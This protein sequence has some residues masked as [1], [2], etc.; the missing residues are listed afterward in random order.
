MITQKQIKKVAQLKSLKSRLNSKVREVEKE[1]EVFEKTLKYDLSK[2]A[3]IQGGQY[4]CR[5]KEGARRPKWKDEYINE[6]GEDAAKQ[7]VANTTPSKDLVIEL[8]S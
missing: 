2:K 4:T 7:V 5:L 8:K 3:K 6:M 1:L